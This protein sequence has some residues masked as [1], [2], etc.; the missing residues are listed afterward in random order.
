VTVTGV[1]G[2]RDGWVAVDLELGPVRFAAVRLAPG[3]DALLSGCVPGQVVGVDMPLG[4]LAEGWR[5]ADR[6]ARALLGPRRSSVFA[7][8]PGPVWREA[9]YAAANERCRALTGSGFS[10]QA[11]G[12]RRKLLEANDYRL[13]CPHPLYEVHP[14]L[15]FRA[16]AGA[17]LRHPKHTAA[18]HAERRALLAGAGIAVPDGLAGA[19]LRRAAVDVLDAAAAAWT[20]ARIAA[21]RARAIP[22]PPQTDAHGRDIAIRY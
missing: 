6:E 1:D 5:A 13:R 22:D 4:L 20:A 8:P 16:M 3:L 10:V 19:A 17:P 21:G 11:W 12:L 15:S 18:G 7:I 14:E 9:G 2:C